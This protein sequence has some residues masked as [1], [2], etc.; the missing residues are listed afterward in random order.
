[1]TLKKEG[2]VVNIDQNNDYEK[3]KAFFLVH[4]NRI[5]CAKNYLVKQ[6]P[7]VKELADFRDLKFAI[8]ETIDDVRMQLLRMRK[9]YDLLASK[10]SIDS[11]KGIIGLIDDTFSAVKL[12]HTDLWR[13]D[14]SI[15]FYLQ[16]IEGIEMASFQMLHLTAFKLANDDIKQLLK[17]NFDEA[18]SDRKLLLLITSKYLKGELS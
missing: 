17:E 11:C 6:L 10:V 4:L 13:R 7:E 5:Y 12:Q 2:I 18:K 8:E 9:V 1:M 3:T 15:L 14:M 16:N